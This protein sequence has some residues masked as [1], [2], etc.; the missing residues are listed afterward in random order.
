MTLLANPLML[1]QK[2]FPGLTKEQLPDEEGLA[3]ENIVA[4]THT[5]THMDA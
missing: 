4:S 1:L 2:Y 3:V 5:G